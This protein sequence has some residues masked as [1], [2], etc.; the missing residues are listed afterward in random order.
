MNGMCFCATK[1]EKAK[2]CVNWDYVKDKRDRWEPF[3]CGNSSIELGIKADPR[4]VINDI[5]YSVHHY[6]VVED[7]GAEENIRLFVLLPVK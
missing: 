2:G 6:M 1:A 3:Y 5:E 7:P 4:L